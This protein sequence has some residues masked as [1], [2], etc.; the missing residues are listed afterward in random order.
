MRKLFILFL[1]LFCVTNAHA[2]W[3]IKT[4]NNIYPTTSANWDS[5]QSPNVQLQQVQADNQG[6]P[7][8]H[9]HLTIKNEKAGKEIVLSTPQIQSG[10]STFIASQNAGDLHITQIGNIADTK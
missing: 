1:L 7:L 6:L 4:D 8:Q 9:L 3:Q 2:D 5:A 10:K